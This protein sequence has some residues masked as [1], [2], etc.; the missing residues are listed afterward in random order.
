MNDSPAQ[1]QPG[2]SVADGEQK[3]LDPAQVEVETT[4]WWIVT[5]SV[6][7][8]LLI[9]LGLCFGFGWL[10]SWL[11]WILVALLGALI[12]WLVW[13]SLRWPAIEHRRCAYRVS[14]LGIEIW[15]GVVWRSAISVPRSRVQHT[16]VSQGPLQR[17]RGLATLSIHTAGTEHSRVELPGLRKEIALEIRDFLLR[18]DGRD[19]G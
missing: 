1:A 19:A 6:A 12:A 15:R 8:P 2:D 14:A 18:G 16:D 13:M 4:V 10:P 7:P 9:G 5:L 17:K 3:P 11:R